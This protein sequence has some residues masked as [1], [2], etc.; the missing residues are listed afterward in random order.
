M[1]TRF[2]IA[3][4]GA[5]RHRLRA[6]GEEALD[7][8]SRI[9]QIFSPYLPSSEI[10]QV[11]ERAALRPVPIG[12]QTLRRLDSIVKLCEATGGAFDITVRPLL[13]AWGLVGGFEPG[14]D[15]D[16]EAARAVTG[17]HHIQLSRQDSTISFDLPGVE[18]D[19]GAVGKGLALDGAAAVL[20]ECGVQSALLHGGTSSVLAIGT[21]GGGRG[22]RAA[23][24]DPDDSGRLIAQTWLCDSSLGVS[25]T[26]GKT[27][28]RNGEV[29]GHIIDPR[30][31]CPAEGAALA[32][33]AAREA[34]F[35]DAFSTALVVL[36]EEGLDLPA[37]HRGDVSCLLGIRGSD[38]GLNVITTG[39]YWQGESPGPYVLE[40]EETCEA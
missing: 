12:H 9:E 30:S 28:V 3:L 40:P 23:V 1:A 24:A 20:R 31:G 14:S 22:W 32:A 38:G 18:L 35:C 19:F 2:E 34:A 16:I 8:I 25:S 13:R 5:E 27:V 29:V 7:E 37:L 17:T 36:G 26:A 4:A 10:Y 21:E 6:A 15:A 11:N 39:P 33:V